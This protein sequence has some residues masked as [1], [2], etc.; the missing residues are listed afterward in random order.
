M[1]CYAII[2]VA[3]SF[4]ELTPD[5]PPPFPQTPPLI[6]NSLPAI[7]ILSRLGKGARVSVAETA[8]GARASVAVDTLSHSIGE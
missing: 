5:P 4:G 7:T 3:N 6:T 8:K 2:T 1:H